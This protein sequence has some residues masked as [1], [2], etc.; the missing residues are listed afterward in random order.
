MIQTEVNTS[1]PEHSAAGSFLQ[2]VLATKPS[3]DSSSPDLKDAHDDGSS[4]SEDKRV[5]KRR[6]KRL[7]S[8]RSSGEQADQQ[9]VR[10]WPWQVGRMHQQDVRLRQHQPP[11]ID[12]GVVPMHLAQ[13]QNSSHS[14]SSLSALTWLVGPELYTFDIIEVLL[15]EVKILL[16][17]ECCG[18]T[19]A[20]CSRKACSVSIFM[21]INAS[22]LTP[23]HLAFPWTTFQPI[24][25]HHPRLGPLARILPSRQKPASQR[26]RCKTSSARCAI[27]QSRLQSHRFPTR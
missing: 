6:K 8:F 13:S 12:L 4:N 16:V 9:D 15:S 5:M 3:L 14:A 20:I 1:S 23:L 25:L 17:G 21:M 11:V 2:A 26:R 27:H 18:K 10:E 24:L 7:L 22:F 19:S